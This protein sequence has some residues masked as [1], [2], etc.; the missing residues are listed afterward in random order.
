[1]PARCPVSPKGGC[2][3]KI[4]AGAR[5]SSPH[6]IAGACSALQGGSSTMVGASAGASAPFLEL[7]A[8]PEQP[9]RQ[10]RHKGEQTEANERRHE[11]RRDQIRG[12]EVDPAIG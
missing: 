9:P 10:Y 1:M 3:S 12:V 5:I 2:G 11:C 4:P 6:H 8:A 7:G